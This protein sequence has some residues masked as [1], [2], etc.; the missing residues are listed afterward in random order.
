MEADQVQF[1][2]E[3][4][5]KIIS[6]YAKKW[7]ISTNSMKYEIKNGGVTLLHCAAGVGKI[8]VVRLL[9]ESGESV[10]TKDGYGCTPLHAA[11]CLGNV[12]VA[13]CLVMEG[14]DIE[15]RDQYG[16]TPLC[17]AEQWS[18]VEVAQFLVSVGAD[19]HTAVEWLAGQTE[20]EQAYLLDQAMEVKEAGQVQFTD[21]EQDK[22]FAEFAEKWQY[23]NV[24]E[25][26][27]DG[28]TL[29]HCAAGLGK[30]E[31]VKS[32]VDAGKNV[33]TQDKYGATPLHV[34][35]E[36]QILGVCPNV[37]VVKFLVSAGADVHAKDNDGDTPLRW[38]ALYGC[39]D[40]LTHFLVS[41]GL[42]VNTKD[43]YGMTLLHH[44]ACESPVEDVDFLISAGAD[45]NVRDNL[46]RTPLHTAIADGDGDVGVIEF[47]VSAG[48][49]VGAKTN[50]GWTPL[51]G[52]ASVGHLA[53]PSVVR[54][55]IEIL[56][57]LVSAGA[58]MNAIDGDGCTPLDDARKMG[59]LEVIKYLESVGAKSE[60]YP[61][62]G[63]GEGFGDGNTGNDA[64]DF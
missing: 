42:D 37:E 56:K 10:N 12:D 21:E 36:V 49:D 23:D 50:D 34:A 64:D 46:G 3:E 32:L 18:N 31:I 62:L 17:L 25:V 29:L 57:F 40:E 30:I 5:A 41:M 59:N 61:L 39:N 51:H 28:R 43:E 7:K 27:A 38:A 45:V 52:A 13:E 19:E 33:N 58:D 8:E 11:A 4:R 60:K 22:I 15:V 6:D 14:A 55:Y 53:E 47:L 24:E 44:A 48:A 2:D 9:I 63:W 35:A 16:A 54:S 20:I 26:K 1:T